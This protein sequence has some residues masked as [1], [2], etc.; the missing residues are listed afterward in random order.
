MSWFDFA[1]TLYN[2][3]IEL[4]FDYMHYLKKKVSFE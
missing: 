4:W 3:K 1:K 2:D